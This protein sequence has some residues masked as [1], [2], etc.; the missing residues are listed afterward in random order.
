LIT[1]VKAPLTVAFTDKSTGTPSLWTWSFGDKTYSTAKSPVHKYAAAG[2]YT[3]SFTIKNI[4]GSD[5]KIMSGYIKVS[6]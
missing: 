4:A 5:T 2:N 1:S 3:V 6:N